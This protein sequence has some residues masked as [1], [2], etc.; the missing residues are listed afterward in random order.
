VL[1]SE[2]SG[3]EV[4]EFREIESGVDKETLGQTC[5]STRTSTIG[6]TFR[7]PSPPNKGSP[8]PSPSSYTDY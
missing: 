6:D 3:A 8:L 1:D 4:S 7:E 2:G 5:S